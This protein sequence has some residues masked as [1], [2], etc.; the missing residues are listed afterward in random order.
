ML[1][2][3][4]SGCVQECTISR[5]FHKQRKLCAVVCGH[6]DLAVFEALFTGIMY[7]V[8]L[9][10]IYLSKAEFLLNVLM[11]IIYINHH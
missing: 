7:Y 9:F 2:M 1:L 10:F 5:A 4:E 6:S 8:T 3:D 11:Y